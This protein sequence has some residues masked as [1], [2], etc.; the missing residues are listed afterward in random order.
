M[1]RVEHLSRV[2]GGQMSPDAGQLPHHYQCILEL[3]PGSGRMTAYTEH[4]KKQ[5][6]VLRCAKDD[7]SKREFDAGE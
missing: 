2:S 7:N 1:R 5:K 6:Q 4:T 3:E